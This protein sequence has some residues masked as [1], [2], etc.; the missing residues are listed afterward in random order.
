MVWFRCKTQDVCPSL[1]G[2]CISWTDNLIPTGHNVYKTWLN[3]WYQIEVLINLNALIYT[4]NFKGIRACTPLVCLCILKVS[5]GF[6]RGLWNLNLADAYDPHDK[7][8]KIRPCPHCTG[9]ATIRMLKAKV[10]DNWLANSLLKNHRNSPRKGVNIDQC[11]GNVEPFLL[12]HHM[13][14]FDY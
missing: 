7:P 6:T 12:C 11:K 3:I 2:V 1:R 5:D 10:H 4:G 14:H 13:R 9:E 8:K